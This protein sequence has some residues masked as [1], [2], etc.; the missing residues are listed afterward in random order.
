[1]PVLDADE[2]VGDGEIVGDPLVFRGALD[3]FDRSGGSAL[4][5]ANVGIF[6]G[7]MVTTQ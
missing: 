5:V 6:S 1:M 4:N 7:D 3:P 2:H